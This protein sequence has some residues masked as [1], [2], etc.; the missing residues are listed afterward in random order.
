[1]LYLVYSID[2]TIFVSVT[3]YESLLRHIILRTVNWLS[4]TEFFILY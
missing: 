2:F 3:E 4:C 1:M